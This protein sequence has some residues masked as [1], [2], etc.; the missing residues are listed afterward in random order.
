MIKFFVEAYQGK[1]RLFVESPNEPSI[2]TIL[3]SFVGGRWSRSKKCWHFEPN[4]QLAGN[5]YKKLSSHS[6][7]DTERLKK[8]FERKDAEK[9]NNQFQLILPQNAAAIRKFELWMI[10][11]RYSSQTVRNYLNALYQFFKHFTSIP[12]S[13]ISND[14]V[15]CFNSEVIIKQNLSTSYQSILVGALKLFFKNTASHAVITG[16]LLRPFKEKRLPEILSKQEVEA[17]LKSVTNLKHKS[18]LSLTY[19]CGLR[20]GEVLNLKL[21]DIDSSRKL[22]HIKQGKGKKDRYVPFGAKIR[23][24]LQQ[25]YKL[26]KPENYLFEGQY[27]GPYGEKSFQEVLQKAVK[28]C[29]VHKQITLH[30]LRHSF[31]THLLESGTDLRYIQELLGHSNPKTTMIYTHVSSKKISEIMSPFDDLDI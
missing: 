17:I 2:T 7:V 21:T 25:Y 4:R 14:H 6:S 3:R 31:A 9:L 10:Q 15:Y 20:R 13:E 28:I 8:Y 5:L 1:E 23:L 18:L 19:A 30:T 11:Q 16:D 22:I 12:Y 27:G 26:Y 24:L 29:H